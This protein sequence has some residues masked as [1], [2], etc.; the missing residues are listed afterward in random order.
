MAGCENAQTQNTEHGLN[1]LKSLS[2]ICDLSRSDLGGLNDLLQ[3]AFASG[4][5]PEEMQ[6]RISALGPFKMKARGEK[7]WDMALAQ[8]LGESD[9]EKYAADIDLLKRETELKLWGADAW[10]DV[11]DAAGA[12]N[13]WVVWF[14]QKPGSR[15]VS[16][17]KIELAYTG[18][19]FNERNEQF[20]YEY[21]ANPEDALTAIRSLIGKP[22]RDEI[23]DVMG[24]IG[25]DHKSVAA[26]AGYQEVHFSHIADDAV[27]SR[28]MRPL[29]WTFIF[30]F[31]DDGAFASAEAGIN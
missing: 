22:S 28:F 8:Q 11:L 5:E 14:V 20:K 2:N 24:K 27:Y 26:V 15:V 19:S 1:G 18:V 25:F 7:A 31:A 10:C 13:L 3:G 30:R 12:Q 6:Q 16:E 9:P 17:A 21:F 29:T 4:V 23:E